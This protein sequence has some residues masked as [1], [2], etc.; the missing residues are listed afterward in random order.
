MDAF[1]AKTMRAMYPHQA[2]AVVADALGCTVQRVYQLAARLGLKK[3]AAFMA[4]DRSGRV[5][6]G[7]QDPRML[8]SQFRPG[9]VPW[10]KG[11]HY[12]PGGRGAESRFQKGHRPQTWVP[13]GSYRIN[14]DGQLDRKMNDKPGPSHVRWFP[15]TRLVWETAHGPVPK[16]SVVVF[17][18]GMR[19]NVLEEITLQRLE[20]ITRGELAQRNHPR[21]KHPELGRLVQLKGAITRQVNRLAREQEASQ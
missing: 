20:C 11:L 7:K 2:S 21:N 19:T 6:R 8:A 1:V 3:S 14:S 18:P 16:G 4:S 13:V 9:L 5:Q 17:R 10:N 15:V 12:M